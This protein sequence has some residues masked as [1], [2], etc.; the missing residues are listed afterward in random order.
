MKK[1]CRGCVCALLSLSCALAS[2]CDAAPSPQE[3]LQA[4]LTVDMGAQKERTVS[5]SLFGVFLEDINYVSFAMDDD[6]IANGLFESPLEEHWRAE[7]GVS[8]ALHEGGVSG[9]CAAAEISR[10]G[11]AVFNSG[12]APCPMAAEKGVVYRFSAFVRA[13]GYE[14]KISLRLQRGR[15][16][17]A[18]AEVSV[19]Q[20]GEWVKYTA[21]MTAAE[22]A[23]A[24]V[25]F[26]MQFEEAG[27]LF[28]DGVSLETTDSTAGIK[29]YMYDAIADLSPRFIRFPGGCAAEG[30][31][32]ESTYDWKNSIGVGA[33]GRAT[34]LTYTAVA[35]DGSREEV[36][37]TGEPVTRTPNTDLWQTGDAYYEMQYGVGFY[38]Y[39]L[40]CERIGA[41]AVPVVSSG[42]TCYFHGDMS[43]LP[44][45][46]GNGA[47]DY[48]RD[49]LD[50]VAFALGDPDSSDENE[51]YWASVRVA[52]GHEEP[53]RMQYIGIGN[54]QWG[55]RY[56]ARYEMFFEAFRA[57][58]EQNPLYGK[59]IPIAGSG[60][61]FA[62]TEREGE[63]G[64][65]REAALA[66]LAEGKIG[67]VSEYGI[68]DHHMYMNYTDFLVNADHYDGY[69]RDP[70]TRYD[71]FVGEYSANQA[72]GLNG[73]AYPTAAN[74]W[75][76][77]LSEAAFM[78]GLERN[79]DVV[80]LAA[81]APMFGC[82]DGK[83][84]QWAVN[85]MY[86]DNTRV[87]PSANYYVQQLFMQNQSDRVL[88]SA[89][90]FSGK[91]AS[92]TFGGGIAADRLYCVAGMDD[93]SGELVVKLVNVGV[94]KIR[95]QV[96][97]AGGQ[98]GEGG[99]AAVLQADDPEAVNDAE[100]TAV[101]P[102]TKE[103]AAGD[104][105]VFELQG[106]SLTILRIP[107]A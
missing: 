37:T 100:H 69:S 54:E 79:G 55:E 40:L 11:G 10:A 70:E 41:S 101:F 7:G 51:A 48:I 3:V 4:S 27:S 58:A 24:G 61:C 90:S 107:A 60:Y 86:F 49:A 56:Y 82:I 22:T 64:L 65:A 103:F 43:D 44:G 39:F 6:L 83:Q 106:Y 21:E 67:S 98:A 78:T 52:M 18:E 95:L 87:L 33:D 42:I 74:S 25:E 2:G 19:G 47:Q 53:F 72:N 99:I 31:D 94:N 80:K 32:M 35:A 75:I 84:N 93:G 29:G 102:Q 97:I 77:A 73:A 105:F 12:Y 63:G 28:L 1:L 104:S 46:N 66:Y 57:A 96:R 85:M 76:S 15:T 8:L 91:G 26:C 17:C 92:C 9:G 14:G 30:R 68:H 62:D 36:T 34:R 89:I 81:Y 16:V 38:E 59:V 45:R 50:L 23:S 20:S 13:D 71:V 88:G 5:D